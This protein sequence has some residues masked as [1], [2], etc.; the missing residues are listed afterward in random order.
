MPLICHVTVETTGTMLLGSEIG[1]ALTALE[2]L[3]IDLIGLN[4]ATGPAEM[5]E[6]LRYLSQHARVPL[7]VMPN[8]GLPELTADGAVLPADP[9]RAGRGAGPVRHRV[10]RRAGRRL[11]RHHAGA[12]PAVV[13]AAARRHARS[14]REPRHEPGVASIYHHVPFAQDAS[15]LMVGERTNANGSKAFREAMLAGDWQA[16][17]EIAREQA[18][19]GS[20]LLDLCVDYVGRDGAAGHARAGRP[21]RHRVDA[22]DH[23]RL[24]RAERDRGRA[25][26][27]S[28]AGASS[29]RSTSRTATGPS[30]RYARV[31]PIVSE[32][33]AAVVALTIDEEGQARTAEWKVRVAGPAH[34]RPHRP[35]GAAPLGHPGRR[36]T[37]PIATG[38]EETRRDGIETI[39]AIR[40]IAAALPGRQLHAGHLQRLVRPQPGRPAGAQLGVPARVRRRPA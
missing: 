2:P 19:D 36:L 37:F 4:C 16:C 21:V 34:R 22:A 30:S 7:S 1:A 31:M 9:G 29:T 11:L 14:P 10:R 35:L 38:Q 20:H 15:V 17:V 32:H 3:G 12:H 28:A 25:W 40:E 33:G 6:H 27:C 26:R 24:D 13:D 18:R 23:A 5:T 39:E 8:A